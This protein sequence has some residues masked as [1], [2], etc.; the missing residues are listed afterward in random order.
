MWRR[1]CFGATRSSAYQPISF[2]SGKVR[3]YGGTTDVVRSGLMFGSISRFGNAVTSQC[4]TDEPG[5]RVAG[6]YSSG[7]PFKSAPATRFGSVVSDAVTVA[8]L[9]RLP[10][11]A[12]AAT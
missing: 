4:D 3:S 2:S 7:F 10:Y 5:M 1:R 12:A 9:E 11:G 6:V 8:G